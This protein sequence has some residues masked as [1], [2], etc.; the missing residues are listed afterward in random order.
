[1]DERGPV[2]RGA[3]ERGPIGPVERGAVEPGAAPRGVDLNP[4]TRARLERIA[5]DALRAA[6]VA[7]VLPTPLEEV[8]R[9]AGIAKRSDIAALPQE[10]ATPGRA[11]LGA[12]WFE[13]REVYVDLAQSEPRRRFTDAHEAMHALCPWHEAVLREDTDAELFRD[14]S[15]AIEAEANYGAGLLLFQGKRFAER[16][17][18]A[19]RDMATALAL[20]DEH[21]AS[22]QATLHHFAQ[23]HPAPVA[24][25]AIGRFPQRD[26]RLPVWRTVASPAFRRR[27]GR[28]GA[29]LAPGRPL[30][31]L[32][33]A[34]RR[35]AAPAAARLRLPDGSGTLRPWT[36]EAHY[37][38]RTFLVLLAG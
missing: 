38:R 24:L 35:F 18:G 4:F 5:E 7:G 12:L 2:E 27:F 8:Q 20:A 22:R 25:L 26:G 31:E 11:L 15:L 19:P 30:R 37:N 13:R 1:M 28:L 16:I 9:A 29:D 10:L 23:H 32:V 17:A 34:A 6:G 3:V 14:T 33:E 36:A 21:G